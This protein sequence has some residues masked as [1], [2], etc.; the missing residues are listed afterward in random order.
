MAFS[1]DTLRAA[2]ADLPA[3][4]GSYVAR[5]RP[6]GARLLRFMQEHRAESAIVDI[7]GEG[8]CI[9]FTVSAGEPRHWEIECLSPDDFR[10]YPG[11]TNGDQVAWANVWVRG[12]NLTVDELIEQ[13]NEIA[14]R[15]DEFANA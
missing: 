1:A 9:L 15:K 3:V 2:L 10:V 4:E 11:V 14:F 5:G 13:L 8:P 6:V 7:T 12:S